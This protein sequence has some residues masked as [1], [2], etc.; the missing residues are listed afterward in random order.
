MKGSATALRFLI[1]VIGSILVA[2]ILVMFF[3]SILPPLSPNL[4]AF[5]DAFLLAV[6][7]FPVLYLALFRPLVRQITETQRVEGR[8][9]KAHELSEAIIGMFP[10]WKS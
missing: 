1:I 6:V 5:L 10:L 7:T 2:E 4:V 8:L 9:R 3:L